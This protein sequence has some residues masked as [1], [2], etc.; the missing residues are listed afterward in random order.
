VDANVGAP[1]VSYRETIRKK[2][3]VEGKFVQQTGGHAQYGHVWITVEPFKEGDEPV[4]FVDA[5]VGGKI[6]RQYV[7]SVEKG[8]RDTAVTGVAGGPP[9]IDIK[10]TLIDGST[11]PVDSSDLAFYTAAC[12]AFRKGVEMANSILLEPIMSIEIT[13]PEQYMGDVIGEVHSR[14][15]NILEMITKGNIRIIKGEVPLA[16]MFGYSTTLRSITQGRGTFT[17]EPLEYRPAPAKSV[18]NVT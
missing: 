10:V 13:V 5:I 11:H 3:E 2:V 9:L 12:I 4:T 18:G 15:A 14:R 1:K 16:E 17:M 8:I 7:R 6:P